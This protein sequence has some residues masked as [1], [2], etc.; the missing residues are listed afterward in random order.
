MSAEED[1]AVLVT[2]E[3]VWRVDLPEFEPGT[4]SGVKDALIAGY[5]VGRAMHIP[6]DKSLELGA[7]S[8]TYTASQVGNEFGKPSDVAEFMSDVTTTS[9][10]T[11]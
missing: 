2:E 3:D 6:L 10:E 1:S 7:A 4:S 8:A 9:Q 11:E 5:L